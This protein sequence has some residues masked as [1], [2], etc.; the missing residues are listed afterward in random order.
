[1]YADIITLLASNGLFEQVQI[2][3]S[4]LKAETDLAPEIDG[5]NALLRALVS[6]KLGELAME[7][8]YLMKEV[9]CEPDKTSFRIVIKGLDATGEAA[10]LRTVKQDAQKI[11]GESLEFLEEENEAATAVPTH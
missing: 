4:Y 8:Y 5:F 10:D 6:Y 3:H 11:Y 9:G 7:S 1:M 2:I